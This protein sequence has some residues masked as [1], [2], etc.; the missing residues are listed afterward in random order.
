M[1]KRE[2]DN[3]R[4]WLKRKLLNIRV[5]CSNIRTS[6]LKNGCIGM[7]VVCCVCL[8]IYFGS[9]Y[10]AISV[11]QSE[12]PAS[13]NQAMKEQQSEQT[14]NVEEERKT[15]KQPNKQTTNQTHNQYSKTFLPKTEW[16]FN[17]NFEIEPYQSHQTIYMF[18]DSTIIRHQFPQLCSYLSTKVRAINDSG[19]VMCESD[20][21]NLT[22]VSTK[23][24]SS[25]AQVDM[26]N[27][28][29]FVQF[30]ANKTKTNPNFIYFNGGLHI[31]HLIP[32]RTWNH[33]IAN[34]YLSW[35]N[36]ENVSLAFTQRMQKQSN[37]SLIFMTSHSICD[38][39]FNGDYQTAVQAIHKNATA[40]SMNCAQWLVKTHN[41]TLQTAMIDCANGVF[42]RFGINLLNQRVVKALPKTMKIVDSFAITDNECEHTNDARH[43]D[44]FIVSQE[45]KELFRV[46]NEELSDFK[47]E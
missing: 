22:I 20:K 14:T 5:S 7:S 19:L 2:R 25:W 23:S 18:G 15:I 28:H 11:K 45:L 31:L 4:R 24:Y 17:E 43:Y 26:Q 47:V 41:V 34:G 16:K 38:S 33:G 27:K 30:V 32:Y 12:Q 21:F 37:A 42:T 36:A 6:Q 13:T 8:L 10:S 46:I 40:F 44:E 29:D 1:R 39:K 3:L 35:K 9:S